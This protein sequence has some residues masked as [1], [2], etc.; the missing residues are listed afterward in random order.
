MVVLG[1]GVANLIS[2]SL[3]DD[4]N[5]F[6]AISFLHAW[7]HWKSS[8]RFQALQESVEFSQQQVETLTVENAVLGESVKS[9]TKGMAKLSKENKNLKVAAF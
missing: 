1:G 3:E 8:T 9:F 6:L 2:I 7:P 5:I 4:K